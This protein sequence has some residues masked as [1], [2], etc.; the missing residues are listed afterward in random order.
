[1]RGEADAYLPGA[2]DECGEKPAKEQAREKTLNGGAGLRG[3]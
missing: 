1:M 2:A 3:G